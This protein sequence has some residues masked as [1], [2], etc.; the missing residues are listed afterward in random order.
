MIDYDISG[1][2][3]NAFAVM[4]N[5]KK[6]M[7]DLDRDAGEALVDMRSADYEHLLDVFHEHLGDVVRLVDEYG[8]AVR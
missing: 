3:G 6:Y 7:K 8:E 4:G 1:P 5:F 2:G